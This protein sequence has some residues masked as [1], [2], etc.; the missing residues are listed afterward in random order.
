MF[1][2]AKPDYDDN[3]NTKSDFQEIEN[4]KY[5]NRLKNWEISE[6][7]DAVLLENRQARRPGWILGPEEVIRVDPQGADAVGGEVPPQDG[8]RRRL[9]GPL[10]EFPATFS[11]KHL[12]HIEFCKFQDEVV[13]VLKKS[14]TGADLPNLLFYGPPGTGKTSTILAAA[15]DD[16]F[17]SVSGGYGK[18]NSATKRTKSQDGF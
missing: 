6:T 1:D 17:V 13:A 9:P 8:G 3:K 18:Q 15:R 14:L 12:L 7:E 10:F 16:T 11:L 2:P 4:S 5:L